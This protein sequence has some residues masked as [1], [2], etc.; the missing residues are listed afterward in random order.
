MEQPHEYIK[1]LLYLYIFSVELWKSTS[2]KTFVELIKQK[3]AEDI[4][5]QILSF[6]ESVACAVDALELTLHRDHLQRQ[7]MGLESVPPETDLLGLR[8]DVVTKYFIT[9][10]LD[11]LVWA[12]STS[13]PLPKCLVVHKHPLDISKANIKPLMRPELNNYVNLTTIWIERLLSQFKSNQLLSAGSGVTWS[14]DP[15]ASLRDVSAPEDAA[16]E[17]SPSKREYLVQHIH[18]FS[19]SSKFHGLSNM[20]KVAANISVLACST[21]FFLHGFHCLIPISIEQQFSYLFP[22][23]N[24]ISRSYSNG[25]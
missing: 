1:H 25:T 10:L 14:N 23:F 13:K 20:F 21:M 16:T 17:F 4:L 11:R 19:E 8:A 6:I 2:T 12:Y 22:G 15:Q 7:G 5:P 24:C 18:A 3:V 9:Q